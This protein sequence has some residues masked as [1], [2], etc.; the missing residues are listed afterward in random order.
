MDFS[1]EELQRIV[2]SI[3]VYV[4]DPRSGEL[5]VEPSEP[6]AREELNRGNRDFIQIRLAARMIPIRTR[7]E[8]GQLVNETRDESGNTRM[9]RV[10]TR[11]LSGEDLL[12]RLQQNT[13]FRQVDESLRRAARMIPIRTRLETGQ[14]VNET[15]DESG[16]TRMSRVPTRELS[17]EDLLQRLQQNA[18]IRQLDESL[19]RA[20]QSIPTYTRVGDELVSNRMDESG[21]F[22]RMNVRRQTPVVRSTTPINED[23]PADTYRR[24][25]EC[26]ICQTNEVNT[27]LIPC[28]HGCCSEC[29]SRLENCHI[30]RAR[31]TSKNSLFLNKYLKYKQKYMNLLNYIHAM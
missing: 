22:A 27:I 3:P 17:G 8:T 21:N 18:E 15:R 29:A 2:R 12:Q 10:P 19:R 30:C 23:I 28:G 26:V 16:N 31:I 14:L 7:L 13:E 4:R 6:A 9:R 5:I 24:R 25:L 11:E 1:N 20:A